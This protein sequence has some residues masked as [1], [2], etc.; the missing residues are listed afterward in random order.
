MD[1]IKL[2]AFSTAEIASQSRPEP[3]C[4]HSSIAYH[5]RIAARHSG[6]GKIQRYHPS[7]GLQLESQDLYLGLRR[8]MALLHTRARQ[9]MHCGRCVV[10]ESRIMAHRSTTGGRVVFLRGT[11]H[12][13][14]AS[15]LLAIM[16]CIHVH[17]VHR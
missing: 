8:W 17:L 14:P 3:V 7:C 9:L 1:D 2:V 13:D 12:N 16:T 4:H 5:H 6:N 15:E 10:H 11:V